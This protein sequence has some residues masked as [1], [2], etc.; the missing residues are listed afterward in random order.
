MPCCSAVVDGSL[1]SLLGGDQE[2]AGD[3]VGV[4]D[5]D[6]ICGSSVGDCRGG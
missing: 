4:L 3:D 5:G 6:D 1:I 2:A